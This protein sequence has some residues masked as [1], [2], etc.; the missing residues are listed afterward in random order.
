[1]RISNQR[2][3]HLRA[4]SAESTMT[5]AVKTHKRD[6][7]N[8]KQVFKESPGAHTAIELL[9]IINVSMTFCSLMTRQ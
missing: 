7:K 5:V 8:E 1:M 4:A 2:T 9:F 3:D 6:K